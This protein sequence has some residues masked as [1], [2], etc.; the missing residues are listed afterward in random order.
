M[1]RGRLPSP[2]PEVSSLPPSDHGAARLAEVR[3]YGQKAILDFSANVNPFGPSPRVYEAL[4]RTPIDRYPD[5]DT[6]L[7][8]EAL[9]HHHGLTPAHILVG[10]GVSELILLVAL[11]FIRPK[12]PCLIV[13]PTYGEYRRSVLL[14]GGHVRTWRAQAENRFRVCPQAI[15]SLLQELPYR[16]VWLCHPNNPTGYPLSLQ[17]LATWADAHP[18]TLFVVDEAYINFVPHLPSAISLQRPNVLILRSM[19]KDYALPGLRLG[20]AVGDP[21]IIQAMAQAQP[22]WS[23]NALAQAAGLAALQD[24]DHLHTTV[25]Q[26]LT[27]RDSL[28]TELRAL[29]WRV[30]VASTPFF[31]MHVGHAR[32]FRERLLAEGVLVRDGTSFGLPEYVRISTRRPQ[33]NSRLITIL[34]R[35][36]NDDH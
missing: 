28:V 32:R 4:A 5:L 14:M 1:T 23:V 36:Y 34:R 8:R 2:R 7:L 3:A 6:L 29:G 27:A 16:V 33:E 22:P 12:D 30:L 20:Y 11:T 35:V 21:A 18:T 26:T 10:N 19:T 15:T 17:D 9:A 31:L 13:E 24:P 25:R